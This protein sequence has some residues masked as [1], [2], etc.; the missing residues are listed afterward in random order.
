MDA[1]VSEGFGP[2]GLNP[3]YIEA[4]LSGL[5]G[6]RITCEEAVRNTRYLFSSEEDDG[7]LAGVAP[8]RLAGTV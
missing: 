8:I 3:R 1:E 4:I 2:V 5:E 7:F 6:E